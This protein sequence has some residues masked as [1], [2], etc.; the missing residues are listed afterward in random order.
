MAPGVEAPVPRPEAGRF[1]PWL[2]KRVP[3]AGETER[4]RGLLHGLRLATVCQS[5]RCPNQCECFSR[6]TATFLILGDVCTRDCAFCAV[7]R[8]AASPPEPDEP[9]RVAEAAAR[10]NLTHVVVTSVTRDDLPDGGAEHFRRTI[11][12]LRARV[13]AA[14]EALTPDFRGQAAAIDAVCSAQPEVYNH[15]IETVP[16]L[17]PSVRPSANYR[18]SLD[19]LRRAKNNLPERLTK[20]GLMAGLGETRDEM[21]AALADL[22]SAGCDLVTIGQYLRPT[23]AHHPVVRFITPEE[24]ED[25]AE[26]AR[27]LGFLSVASAPF[28]RSSYHAADMFLDAEG[29]RAGA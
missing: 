11:L 23:S 27:R 19:L 6:G 16:R 28:V 14:V 29:G 10:M 4:V 18:Q 17:Y 9:D 8:G 25:Y 21:L 5:A 1:P 7:R 15:N 22:R 12:A 2:K 26:E 3:A 13:R 20:S 24:F